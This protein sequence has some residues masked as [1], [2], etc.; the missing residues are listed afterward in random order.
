MADTLLPGG[1]SD[2]PRLDTVSYYDESEPNWDERP[3][4]TKVEE[5]RG[6]TGCHIEVDSDQHLTVSLAWDRFAVMPAAGGSPSESVNKFAACLEA[7]KSRVVLSGIGGDESNGGVPTPTPRLADLV[8]RAHLWTLTSELKV[9]ALNK[10]QPW[11][12]LLLEALRRFVPPGFRGLPDHVRPASWFHEAFVKRNRLAFHRYANRLE[13]FG[14]LP[15]FQENLNALNH[16]RRKLA[17]T[18]LSQDQ[19]YEKRYPYL[20]RSFLE[21]I[22]AIPREQLV[23]PGQRRSLMRRALVG[24]VPEEILNRKRK[25]YV[26]RASMV[27]I[28]RQYE[29]LVE[30]SKNM[31]TSSLGMVMPERFIE[32]LRKVQQ[33]QE[34]PIVPLLRTIGIEQ[35]LA[36]IKKRGMLTVSAPVRGDI[37]TIGDT[38]VLV[39]EGRR[40]GV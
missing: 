25:A 37:A 13:F 18:P 38:G 3:F 27:A 12:H 23:R 40:N 34:V 2:A 14:P 1:A 19:I 32:A 10:R 21:F 17:C 24:I 31:A 9:W 22:Y 26:S 39:R 20:D 35:W 29:A 33:G 16:L 30:M 36:D 4:F 7:H 5:K 15:S 6:R 8:A 28:S 11:W